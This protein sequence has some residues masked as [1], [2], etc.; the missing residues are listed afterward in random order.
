MGEGADDSLG[1]HDEGGEYITDDCI[2]NV[3][4]GRA[5]LPGNC[6]A[7]CVKKGSGSL[8]T[9]KHLGRLELPRRREN[10]SQ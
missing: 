5:M 10:M 9:S 1:V 6:C 7:G 8:N 3:E 2:G 4:Q